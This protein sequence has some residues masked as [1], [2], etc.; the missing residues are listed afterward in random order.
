MTHY[1]ST[2]GHDFESYNLSVTHQRSTPPPLATSVPHHAPATPPHS[3]PPR[4][5]HGKRGLGRWILWEWGLVIALLAGLCITLLVISQG[6]DPRRQANALVDQM[7]AAALGHPPAQSPFGT[8]PR[9]TRGTHDMLVSQANVP[10]KICVLAGWDLFRLG[11]ITINGVTP[12][13]VSAEKLVD[14]CN[15]AETATLVWSPRLVAH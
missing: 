5:R 12:L 10:P 11:N 15:Q 13:R 6:P 9:V 8:P 1:G 4:K 14:L 3:R 7:K 2:S